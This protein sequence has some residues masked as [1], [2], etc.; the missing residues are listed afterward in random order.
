MQIKDSIDVAEACRSYFSQLFPLNPGGIVPAGPTLADLDLSRAHG[1][2]SSELKSV[3]H[4]Q[5]PKSSAPA[6][7]V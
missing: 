7:P 1:R 5:S 2:G 6:V 3:F 4:V